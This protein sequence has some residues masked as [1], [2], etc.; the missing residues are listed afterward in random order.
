MDGALRDRL[1]EIARRRVDERAVDP[2]VDAAWARVAEGKDRRMGSALLALRGAIV[3]HYRRLRED[4][5]REQ[6]LLR[7]PAPLP[8]EALRP[9]ELSARMQAAL[10]RLDA[11]IPNASRLLRQLRAAGDPERLARDLELDLGA[12]SR[13]LAR[14]RARLEELLLAEGVRP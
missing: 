14:A 5:A 9:E 2:V 4:P 1:R 10:T 12:L 13:R 8:I 11:E 3:D 6:A 7:D